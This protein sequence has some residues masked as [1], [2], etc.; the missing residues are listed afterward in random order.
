MAKEGQIKS[1]TWLKCFDI[2]DTTS[3]NTEDEK[4]NKENW[5]VACG[6]KEPIM[7]IDGRHYQYYWEQISGKRAYYCFETDLFLT[8]GLESQLP[9]CLR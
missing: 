3:T 9:E 4:M 1:F 8:D 5:T 6:G 7:E 2:L